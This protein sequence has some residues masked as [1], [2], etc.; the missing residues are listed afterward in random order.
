MLYMGYRFGRAEI[1]VARYKRAL[2]PL[3]SA[4]SW[5]CFLRTWSRHKHEFT[6]ALKC[7]H[8]TNLAPELSYLLLN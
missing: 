4:Y 8:L 6:R 2:Y 1:S 7:T 5:Y 3:A